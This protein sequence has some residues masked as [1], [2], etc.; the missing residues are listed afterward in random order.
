M[1][2]T[3]S[4]GWTQSPAAAPTPAQPPPTPDPP[5]PWTQGG[6][7][8]AGPRRPGRGARLVT[9]LLSVVAVLLTAATVTVLLL[10]DDDTGGTAGSSV[11]T[12]PTSPAP[13]TEA[14]ATDTTLAPSSGIDG[15]RVEN[16]E[17]AY[18]LPKGWQDQPELHNLF[19]GS[20]AGGGSE[21]LQVLTRSTEPDEFFREGYVAVLRSPVTEGMD[22]DNSVKEFVSGADASGVRAR[23]RGSPKKVRLAGEEAV[24]FD[25]VMSSRGVEFRGTF[26]NAVHDDVM[27]I[28]TMTALADGFD[29]ASAQLRHIT[30]TWRWR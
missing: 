4:D 6:G 21:V 10:R 14:D 7:P 13:D 8:I 20:S 24:K 18:G 22:L 19:G 9:A 25:Y 17:F 16:D 3:Q 5:G 26:V 27:Y 2:A 30:S 28:V 11:A 12:S 1:S 29:H 23:L 15:P